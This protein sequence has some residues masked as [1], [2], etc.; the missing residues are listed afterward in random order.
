MTPYRTLRSATA[1][2][3]LGVALTGFTS[4]SEAANVNKARAYQIKS[5]QAGVLKYQVAKKLRAAPRTVKAASRPSVV[6]RLPQAQ[7]R[8]RAATTQTRAVKRLPQAQPRAVNNAHGPDYAAQR[9]YRATLQGRRGIDRGPGTDPRATAY[10]GYQNQ[11]RATAIRGFQNPAQ[12]TAYRGY[13]NQGR[14]TAYRGY[15]N[16]DRASRFTRRGR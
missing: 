13:Q 11:G 9:A 1:L 12:S 15:Q 10:R 5:A 7:V 2:L 16:Q 14:A 6:K 3:A 4:V 8:S